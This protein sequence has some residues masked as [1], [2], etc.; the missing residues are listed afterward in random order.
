MKFP[1]REARHVD[2]AD[3][4]RQA[5]ARILDKAEGLGAGKAYKPLLFRPIDDELYLPEQAWSKLNFV[6]QEGEARGF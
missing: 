2:Y 1:Q 3:A 6:Y 5:L 4:P